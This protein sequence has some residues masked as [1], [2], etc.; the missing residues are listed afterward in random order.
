MSWVALSIIN[1]N[2]NINIKVIVDCFKLFATL[3]S[4]LSSSPAC[5]HLPYFCQ[6]E[7]QT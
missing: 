5:S 4:R 2:I 7:L 6:T 1:I 3:L